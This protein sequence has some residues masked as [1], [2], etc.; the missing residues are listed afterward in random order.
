MRVA[1]CNSKE[2]FSCYYCKFFSIIVLWGIVLLIVSLFILLGMASQR[3]R[4][5][6]FLEALVILWSL[7]VNPRSEIDAGNEGLS[8]VR[9]FCLYTINFPQ[10][11]QLQYNH[12][13]Y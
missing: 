10:Y 9:A 8:G 12:R 1:R 6:I 5:F 3:P 2:Q 4:K 13:D 11:N 7:K